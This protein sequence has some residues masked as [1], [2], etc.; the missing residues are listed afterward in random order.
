MEKDESVI[1][2]PVNRR[3]PLKA[4]CCQEAQQSDWATRRD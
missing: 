3:S 4:E 2:R 1:K